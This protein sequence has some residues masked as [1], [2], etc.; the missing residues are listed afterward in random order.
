[1]NTTERMNQLLAQFQADKT[2]TNLRNVVTFWNQNLEELSKSDQYSSLSKRVKEAYSFN[3]Q[4]RKVDIRNRL[5][6]I[7][8]ALRNIY[9]KK[10]YLQAV[11]VWN[12]ETP[13]IY[14]F[15][16]K[17]PYDAMFLDQYEN[18]KNEINNVYQ[19]AVKT[20][21]F[22]YVPMSIR[23]TPKTLPEKKTKLSKKALATLAAAGIAGI[24]YL[25]GSS[26]IFG[27][28]SDMFNKIKKNS[29]TEEQDI[30]VVANAKDTELEEGIIEVSDDQ[31]V[32][33]LLSGILN[34]GGPYGL[35]VSA[36]Q[37]FDTWLLSNYEAVMKNAP[38]NNTEYLERLNYLEV[39]G[40]GLIN[41]QLHVFNNMG[42]S[43]P[44]IVK[45]G[46]TTH[47][48]DIFRA[49]EERYETAKEF[50]DLLNQVVKAAYNGDKETFTKLSEQLVSTLDDSYLADT[51][52][53][54]SAALW[55]LKLV[56]NA[57]AVT[58]TLGFPMLDEVQQHALM[59]A[60][61][62]CTTALSGG[63]HD[64][65][66]KAYAESP[67]EDL[68]EGLLRNPHVIEG[69][70]TR[71]E[72]VEM[73]QGLMKTETYRTREEITGVDLD[74]VDARIVID[75]NG[76][77]KVI[78]GGFAGGSVPGGSPVKQEGTTT[79]TITE[80]IPEQIDPNGPTDVILDEKTDKVDIPDGVEVVG[81][82]TEDPKYPIYDPDKDNV[83][84]D[85]QPG[86]EESTGKYYDPWGNVYDSAAERDQAVRDY[87]EKQNQNA[88]SSSSETQQEK[89]TTTQST[90]AP[91]AESTPAPEATPT[92]ETAGN[93]IKEEVVNAPITFASD[94]IDNSSAEAKVKAATEAVL[95][96]VA[97]EQ[98]L[99]AQVI[100]GTPEN[101]IVEET[102]TLD[103]PSRGLSK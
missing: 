92:P 18:L 56:D 5:N 42:M 80:K 40:N 78:S 2:V 46:G 13:A 73:I 32:V 4:V 34:D 22:L 52:M 75:E 62:T 67:A 64:E 28:I 24:G 99:Q 25:F 51:K 91:D 61:D 16:T 63:F 58:S 36:D 93:V 100:Y 60:Q 11:E 59:D 17:A 95:N 9:D 98:Q 87:Y 88:A 102:V 10:T 57:D 14:P 96:E 69:K 70:Y 35:E 55:A 85:E 79:S 74:D 49:S 39:S 41:T 101:T 94:A 12:R 103:E 44:E 8:H 37:I 53:D 43:L 68:K 31:S 76:K 26:D 19:N 83:S 33:N 21:N 86:K 23:E 30:V 84:E 65:V 50:E 38:Y 66:D 15:I 77:V 47:Y 90:P 54:P 29:I 6:L 48:S 45:D 3:E 1:M 20:G 81:D 71:D 82:E 72:I 89:E 7:D 97:Q 27:K